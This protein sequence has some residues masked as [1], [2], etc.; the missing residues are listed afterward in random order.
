[1]I[2][3][4]LTEEQEV[5]REAIRD[6]AE[7]VLRPLARECDEAESIPGD[8]LDTVWELGLTSTQIPAAFGGGGEDRS[9]ITNAIILEELAHGDATLAMA[10]VAPS[11]FANAIVDQGSEQ[12]KQ[13]YLPLFCGERFHAASLAAI[14]S[15]AVSDPMKPRTLAEPKEE[16]FV[17]SGSKAL[18]PL[19]RRASHFLVTARNGEEGVDAFIVPADAE[20]LTVS[21]AEKNLGLRGLGTVSLTL[22]RVEVPAADRLGGE[23]GSD[24]RRVFDGSRAALAAVMLGLSRAVLEYCVPYTKD[25]VAFDEPIAQKQAIAFRLADMHIEI[26]ATRWLVWKAASQLERGLETTRSS[27]FARSYA[28][29]K[30]MWIADNGIQTLGGHGFIRE[31]PVEMWFRNARSLGVLEG[32]LVL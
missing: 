29:E 5:V 19:G 3:Y 22:D 28:A 26:E 9:P 11:A 13:K 27:H 7:Q 4:G 30:S 1:M 24:L 12:Q 8:F 14:E 31:H 16:G 10:A 15:A 18:V 2:S 25:R 32:T 23:Q 21:D 6:F 17:I 20:G